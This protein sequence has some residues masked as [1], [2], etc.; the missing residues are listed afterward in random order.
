[1]LHTLLVRLHLIIKLTPISIP[2]IVIFIPRTYIIYFN[3]I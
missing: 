3:I 1:M 2:I